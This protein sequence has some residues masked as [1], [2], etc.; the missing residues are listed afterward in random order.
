MLQKSLQSSRFLPSIDRTWLLWK[1]N[2]F[3]MISIT[4]WGKA[5]WRPPLYFPCF[6]FISVI[7]SPSQLIV[8]S[9]RT[10][11]SSSHSVYTHSP[12]LQST[13]P[14]WPQMQQVWRGPERGGSPPCRR[15]VIPKHTILSIW[16][17]AASLKEV[18][19]NY[20]KFKKTVQRK[21]RGK[22]SPVTT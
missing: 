21:R 9:L 18:T 17:I 3:L 8:N 5:F 6:V 4:L 2:F 19:I 1:Y 7:S 12:G 20:L 11:T 10:E 16:G 15:P 14:H 22:D 13:G